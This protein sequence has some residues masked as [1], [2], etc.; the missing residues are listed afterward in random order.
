MQTGR[1]FSSNVSINLTTTWS[2]A[3]GNRLSIILEITWLREYSISC[4]QICSNTLATKFSGNDNRNWSRFGMNRDGRLVVELT[5]ILVG[6]EFLIHYFQNVQKIFVRFVFDANSLTVRSFLVVFHGLL[7]EAFLLTFNA[8][9][10]HLVVVSLLD[11]RIQKVLYARTRDLSFKMMRNLIFEFQSSRRIKIVISTFV[12][13]KLLNVLKRSGGWRKQKA[14]TFAWNCRFFVIVKSNNRFKS[15]L[16]R[17]FRNNS[18]L[19]NN[20][21]HVIHFK[22]ILGRSSGTFKENFFHS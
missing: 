20:F 4:P 17:S 14:A 7:Q 11:W 6:F 3:N 5:F 22:S 12:R 1:I 2:D 16:T 18:L 21:V 19:K 9:V 13:V 10:V 15:S 8:S